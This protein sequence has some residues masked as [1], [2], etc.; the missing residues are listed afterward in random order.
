[1]AICY[2]LK[3]VTMGQPKFVQSDTTQVYL[4][5]FRLV[6]RPFS[7]MSTQEHIEEDTTEIYGV[8]SHIHCVLQYHT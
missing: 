2:V 3:G 8:S 7:H 1:M 5:M 4:I 6:L